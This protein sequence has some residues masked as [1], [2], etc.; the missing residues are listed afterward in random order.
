VE[1]TAK[2]LDLA[3]VTT[4][5]EV[6]TSSTPL[7]GFSPA[8]ERGALELKR[9]LLTHLYHHHRVLRATRKAERILG[10]LYRIYREEP[11]QL[12][13]QVI[14][15]G[16]LDGEA[17]AVADY[18]AGMTDRFALDEHRKLLDPHEPV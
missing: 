14:A 4:L 11:E 6:R 13:P 18:I 7:V 3:K 5:A 10:D 8:V 12:P 1:E 9:F 15:R 16:A 2:R 17:R